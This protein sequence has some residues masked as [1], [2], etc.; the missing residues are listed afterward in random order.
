MHTSISKSETALN[1]LSE[2]EIHLIQRPVNRHRFAFTIVSDV[3]ARAAI[4]AR[5]G[6]DSFAVVN[7]SLLFHAYA[8][9]YRQCAA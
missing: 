3:I 8:L 7:F 5:G 6:I 1:F 9:K 4:T 2:A